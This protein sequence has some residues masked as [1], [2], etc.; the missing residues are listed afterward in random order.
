[1]SQEGKGPTQTVYLQLALAPQKAACSVSHEGPTLRVRQCVILR[2]MRSYSSTRPIGPWKRPPPHS[3]M[4][5]KGSVRRQSKSRSSADGR[6]KWRAATTGQRC[7]MPSSAIF[8]SLCWLRS[9]SDSFSTFSTSRC[10]D[11]CARAEGGHARN[12]RD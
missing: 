6:T 1:M 4:K 12:C 11:E 5:L 10:H 3:E 7:S 8:Y 9:I 2:K